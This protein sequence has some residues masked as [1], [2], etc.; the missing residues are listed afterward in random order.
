MEFGNDSGDDGKHVE[1]SRS[2]EK[3]AS[4]I[5]STS[6]SLANQ[7]EHRERPANQRERNDSNN[8][9]PHPTGIYLARV[10]II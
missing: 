5:T 3:S 4:S 8:C 2:L 10:V 9:S 6:I 7:A 1:R